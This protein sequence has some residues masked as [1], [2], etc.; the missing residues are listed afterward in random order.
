M[1]PEKKQRLFNCLHE[2][3]IIATEDDMNNIIEIINPTKYPVQQG[4]KDDSTLNQKDEEIAEA[5]KTSEQWRELAFNADA[6]IQQLQ[7]EL[8]RRFTKE[9][10]EKAWA[11]IT[12]CLEQTCNMPSEIKNTFFNHL[13]NLKKKGGKG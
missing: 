11:A 10:I 13:T 12:E 5:W 6:K 8:E 3:G 9:D 4:P 2:L 7:A 1:T